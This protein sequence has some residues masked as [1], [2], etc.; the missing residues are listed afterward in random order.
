MQEM[1][2]IM[3]IL[4]KSVS[5]YVMFRKPVTLADAAEWSAYPATVLDR[6]CRLLSALTPQLPHCFL[7]LFRWRNV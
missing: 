3:L 4:T 1:I 2:S 5:F 7:D 6:V